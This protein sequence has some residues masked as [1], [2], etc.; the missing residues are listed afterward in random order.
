MNNPYPP[1]LAA[2]MCEINEQN[3]T[4]PAPNK[5][6]FFD[7]DIEDINANILT[8]GRML[9]IEGGKQTTNPRW[10]ILM[11]SQPKPGVTEPVFGYMVANLNE[12]ETLLYLRGFLV[13]M[14]EGANS[15]SEKLQ[16]LVDAF[17]PLAKKA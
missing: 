9:K 16:T 12:R 1:I 8:G 7:F 6:H 15:A 11:G 3:N 2:D 10:N 14:K 4:T 13:G 5:E 17:L